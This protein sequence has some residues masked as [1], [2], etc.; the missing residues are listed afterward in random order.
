MALPLSS[1]NLKCIV[2]SFNKLL[3]IE[4]GKFSLLKREIKLQTRRLRDLQNNYSVNY[5]L[6]KDKV[7]FIDFFFFYDKIVKRS[8]NILNNTERIHKR[9]LLDLGIQ[10]IHYHDNNIFN[11][12]NRILNNDERRLLSLGLDFCIPF[13]KVNFLSHF[14][15]HA[16]FNRFISGCYNNGLFN[17]SKSYNEFTTTIAD[18]F[19]NNFRFATKFKNNS[20]SPVFDKSDL[21]TLKNLKSDNSIVISR[22]DKGRGVVVMNK[23]DYYSKAENILNNSG[24]FKLIKDDTLSV[25]FRLEDKINRLLRKIKDNIGGGVYDKLYASGSQPGIM[26]CLPKVHKPNIPLR[27]IISS[28]NT[29]GYK[30]AKFLLPILSPFTTNQYTLKDSNSFIEFINNVSL[31]RNF[32]MEIIA[33]CIY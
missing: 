10:G 15:S 14:L 3:L 8:K 7:S 9:K 33:I 21:D 1:Y 2:A 32:V 13:Y 29:A 27:P 31:P 30:L 26:Y 5:Q 4:I 6:F 12:S 20:F 17:P 19:K 16:R 11:F 24:I 23:D 18:L 25:I 28:I 22:P